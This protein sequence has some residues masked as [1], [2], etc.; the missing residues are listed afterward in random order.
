[1][2]Q[3]LKIVIV[4]LLL[5]CFLQQGTGSTSFTPESVAGKVLSKL[6]EASGQL[7]LKQPVLKM[8]NE[9]KR[10]AA[11][12]PKD[13]SIVLDS[14]AYEVCRN[15]GQDSLKALAFILG[16]ELAHAFQTEVRSARKSTNFLSY[17]K[18]FSSQTR[19]EKVADI[20]GIFTAYLAGFKLDGVVQQVLPMLYDAYGLTGKD[21][22]GYPSLTERKQSAREVQAIADTLIEVFEI[23]NYLIVAEKYELAGACLEYVMKYYQGREIYNNL[24]VMYVLAAMDYYLPAT[25]R[26]VYPVELDASTQLKKIEKARG[27]YELS[28]QDRL[29]RSSLLE[30]ALGNFRQAIHLDKKYLSAKINL[31][32]ALNLLDKPLEAL[33]FAKE[34]KLLPP[35]GKNKVRSPGLNVALGISHALAGDRLLAQAEFSAAQPDASAA[36]KIQAQYNLNVLNGRELIFLPNHFFEFPEQFQAQ[37]Q[38]I[39]LPRMSQ[40]TALQIAG[41]GLFLKMTRQ[42]NTSSFS[43]GNKSGNLV[44]IVK[45]QNKLAPRLHLLELTTT[46]DKIFFYNLVATPGGYYLKSKNAEHILKVNNKGEVLEMAR[47]YFH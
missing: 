43:F 4:G 28:P 6:F 40:L 18:H 44:S 26:Y 17:D 31:I 14:K 42:G 15:L 22:P 9:H 33:D 7:N 21:L 10:V 39:L 2:I 24:G 34:T 3:R 16:H 37:M 36:T 8:T 47:L 13:N 32:C 25:D 11:Y 20:Q 45:F 41:T 27:G 38:T 1:M 35:G 23:A 19:V 30:K 46:L 12:F 29:I 5:F